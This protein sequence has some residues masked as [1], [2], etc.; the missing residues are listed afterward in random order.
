MQS[1]QLDN[2]ANR[3][4]AIVFDKG[5][6]FPDKLIEFAKDNGLFGG[7]FNAIGAFS[8]VTL[9]YFDLST[10]EY[11]RNVIDEQV[12]VASIIGNIGVFNDEPKLHAHAVVGR[13]DGSSFAGHL[14]EGVVRPTLEIFLYDSNMRLTREIDAETGLPLLR[15]LSEEVG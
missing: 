5:E 3:I 7:W 13:R 6:V 11:E 1:R 15:F 2:Q 12:E 9:A 14:I 10:N 4:Y 8:R